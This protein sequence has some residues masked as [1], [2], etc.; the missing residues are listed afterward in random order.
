MQFRVSN[1]SVSGIDNID[2]VI[3][4]VILCI[5]LDGVVEP[6]KVVRTSSCLNIDGKRMVGPEVIL[7]DANYMNCPGAFIDTVMCYLFIIVPS[8]N[9]EVIGAIES[10]HSNII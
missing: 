4:K 7:S 8:I 1:T 5:S 10:H 6:K 3:L 2:H 9:T